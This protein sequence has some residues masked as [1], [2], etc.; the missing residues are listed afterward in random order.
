VHIIK[1]KRERLSDAID[2]A[3]PTVLTY[4]GQPQR[5]PKCKAD[6]CVLPEKIGAGVS[7]GDLTGDHKPDLLIG[8]ASDDYEITPG[9]GVAMGHTYIVS[10]PVAP[11]P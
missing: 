7:L 9:P 4:V 6:P 5:V 3:S 11:T 2:L 8:A 10:A 1:G